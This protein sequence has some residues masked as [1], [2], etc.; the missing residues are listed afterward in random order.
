MK[1]A[2]TPG[3][4]MGAGVETHATACCALATVT[5]SMASGSAVEYRRCIYH[6]WQ[7]SGDRVRLGT[8][9]LSQVGLS[10]K[11]KKFANAWPGRVDLLQY[12]TN[13]RPKCNIR[14]P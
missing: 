11:D 13:F 7:V 1:T 3:L 4:T 14:G 12:R 10:K 6:I 2:R 9:S 8:G 5:P